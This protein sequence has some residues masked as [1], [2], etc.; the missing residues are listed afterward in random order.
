MTSKLN[1]TITKDLDEIKSIKTNILEVED[2]AIMI[3]VAGWVRRV[4]FDLSFKELEAYRDIKNYYK[5]KLI[6]INYIGDFSDAHTVKL[7]PVKTFK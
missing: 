1:K 6:T 4:Y 7:L 5:G 2:N 3:M